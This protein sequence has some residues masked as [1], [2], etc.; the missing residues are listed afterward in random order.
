MH[1][2]VLCAA[3][4]GLSA[5]ANP[6]AS[7]EYCGS[8]LESVGERPLRCCALRASGGSSTID[9]QLSYIQA[10]VSCR[11]Q[12]S[13]GVFC[14]TW[15]SREPVYP[16]LWAFPKCWLALHCPRMA[17]LTLVSHHQSAVCIS[18]SRH[19][20]GVSLLKQGSGAEMRFLAYAGCRINHVI[21]LMMSRLVYLLG[22]GSLSF[23]LISSRVHSSPSQSIWSSGILAMSF[24]TQSP[25]LKCGKHRVV[26]SSFSTL[27]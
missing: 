12:N 2:G 8:W 17:L 16:P 20:G 14:E 4:L 24:W 13:R 15:R 21:V 3:P 9:C 6:A 7:E 10:T 27:S 5:A 19:F 25:F 23:H 22:R 1:A 26:F 11:Y 18:V